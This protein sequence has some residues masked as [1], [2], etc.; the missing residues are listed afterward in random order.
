M[1]IRVTVARACAAAALAAAGHATAQDAWPAKPVHL[2]IGLPAGA[3]ADVV[4]RVVAAS[5]GER[6]KQAVLVENRPGAA[7]NIAMEAVAKSAPDGYTLFFAVSSLVIN[8]HIYKLRFDPMTELVPVSHVATAHFVLAAK[9]SLPAG[10]VSEL[11]TLAKT[12]PGRVTCAHSSG[13]LHIGCAWLKA[14]G[15]A[16]ITLVPYKGS[17]EALQEVIAERTDL[18][19]AVV[20]TAVSAAK[21]GRIKPLATADPRRGIGPFGDLP[22]VAETLPGFALTAFLGVM[23]P[24]GTPR[25]VIATLNREIAAVL[26]DPA[27]RKRIEDSGLQVNGGTPEAFAEAIK[28]DYANYGRIIRETGIKVQ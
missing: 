12:Q 19:F 5:L 8:P 13:A 22:T 4:A 2:V 24:A 20:H 21:A 9:P 18:V 26:A 28:R 23:A 25:L 1:S 15:G 14:Q 16:D 7:E 10:S 17:N 11:L 6:L 27:T 3:G